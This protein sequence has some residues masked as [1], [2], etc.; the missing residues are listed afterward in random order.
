MTHMTMATFWKHDLPHPA[1]SSLCSEFLP[2]ME[3]VAIRDA[4]AL[5]FSSII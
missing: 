3:G 1:L 4:Q 5:I 2:G